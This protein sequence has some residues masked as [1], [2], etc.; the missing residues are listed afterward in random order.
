MKQTFLNHLPVAHRGLHGNGIPEN[1]VPAFLKAIEAG[2]A[3]ETDVRLSKDGV[4]VVFHDD[5]LVR[6]TGR[7]GRVES[8]T[9][10]QLKTLS[11][12]NTAERI[13][14]FSEFLELLGGKVPLLLEIKNMKTD[15][16]TF[17]G[18]IVRALEGYAGEYAVQ[19][20]NPFYVKEFKTL[21]P[22]IPCGVLATAQSK[23]SDFDGSPLWRIKARAIKTMSFNKS[24][25]PDFISYNFQDYPQKS[26]EKFHG[27][28]LGWTVRSPE[29]EAVA[30]KY[31]D[32]IIFE[33]YLP[34]LKESRTPMIDKSL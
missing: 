30:R 18:K 3:I 13:P 5:T 20:F 7:N 33:N 17:I 4:P 21:R 24:V 15:R 31:C 19:S 1:S 6:M 34:Q 23:K 25:K 8:L 11:L 9:A 16:K 10:E 22:E 12:Q 27:L 2:Y 14:L 29:E 26:T 28:K 32:N